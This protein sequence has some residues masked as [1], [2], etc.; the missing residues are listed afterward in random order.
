MQEEHKMGFEKLDTILQRES[1][2]LEQIMNL[3]IKHFKVL[4]Q[5][6]SDS[7]LL[8]QDIEKE[9]SAALKKQSAEQNKNMH[10]IQS[11]QLTKTFKVQ[12]EETNKHIRGQLKIRQREFKE[13]CKQITRE[14]DKEEREEKKKLKA[15]GGNP[16]DSSEKFKQKRADLKDHLEKLEREF[17][18]ESERFIQEED[19]ELHEV[20]KRQRDGMLNQHELDKKRFFQELDKR[21]RNQIEAHQNEQR[22]LLEKSNQTLIQ[23]FKSQSQQQNDLAKK[24]SEQLMQ[25]LNSRQKEQM[26][27]LLSFHENLKKLSKDM[28]KPENPQEFESEIKTLKDQHENEEANLQ[29]T[30][31]QRM[32]VLANGQ[33]EKAKQLKEWYEN[34]VKTLRQLHNQHKRAKLQSL[35]RQEREMKSS[36]RVN[37]I[38][39]DGQ[40]AM[41]VAANIGDFNQAFVL[42]GEDVDVNLQDNKGY[43]A[44]HNACNGKN[45]HIVSLLLEQANIEVTLRNESGSTALHYF[46]KK[47]TPDDYDEEKE[48]LVKTMISKGAQVDAE[49]TSG[50]TPLMNT[51]FS[52]NI[53]VANLLI[54]NGARVNARTNKVRLIFSLKLIFFLK[55]ISPLKLISDFFLETDFQ[56]NYFFF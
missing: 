5:F 19:N 46:C 1:K 33:T 55:L 25:N 22:E 47:F 12:S 38:D 42:I 31:R 4:H 21:E 30:I 28:K 36:L 14:L 11:E 45:K 53:S 50:E 41:H 6:R 7:R 8:S 32:E 39:E 29:T 40:T 26:E 49:N 13:S 51:A 52:Q 35:K 27:A 37:K 10:S 43:T 15:Q 9:L 20:Q 44:L 34:E 24:H 54:E 23:I 2:Q 16:K 48:G 18:L 17:Q 56:T 3:Q